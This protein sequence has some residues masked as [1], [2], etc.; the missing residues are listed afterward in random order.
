MNNII[1]EMFD[2][3]GWIRYNKRIARMFSIEASIMFGELVSAASYWESNADRYCALTGTEFDGT[4]FHTRDKIQENT[5]LSAFLQRKGEKQLVDAGFIRVEKKGLPSKNYYTII[6]ENVIEFFETDTIDGN[7][8]KNLTTVKSQNARL[9]SHRIDANKNRVIRTNKK[10]SSST[11]TANAAHFLS[12]RKTILAMPPEKQEFCRKYEKE[13]LKHNRNLEFPL[14][15]SDITSLNKIKDIEDAAK[16]IPV[17]WSLDER[18]N[19]L[20]DS[21]HTMTIF[22][23]EYMSGK[24]TSIYPGSKQYWLDK[25]KATHNR[26]DDQSVEH[27]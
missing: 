27:N 2:T 9:Y 18:D 24:L 19:W 1:K 6:D 10:N 15:H 3:A 22:A 17:L 20:R 11:T 4:F 12:P 25:Q 8:S 5:A 21:D 7:K 13:W 16:Y 14:K 26:S 23:K